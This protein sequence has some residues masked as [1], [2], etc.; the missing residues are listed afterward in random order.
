[1][2]NLNNVAKFWKKKLKDSCTLHFGE[3]VFFSKLLDAAKESIKV[4]EVGVGRGRM[5]KILKEKD[6]KAEFYGIDITDNVEQSGTIGVIGDARSLP[7]PDNTFDLV[8]SLGTVEHFPETFQ[9]VLEHARVVKKGG[10]VLIST[11]RLSVFSPLR[12]LVYLIRDRKE[13]NFEEIRGRNIRLSTMKKYFAD[14]NLKIVDCCVYGLYGIQ[15]VLKKFNIKFPKRLYQN[16]LIGAYLY[17]IGVKT[18][19]ITKKT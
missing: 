4:L 19:D 12:F 5:A 14:S 7:Y 11:P 10:K 8:Y 3:E 9:A 17:V 13:G 15:R 18:Y 2:K 1:M 16:P 6:V